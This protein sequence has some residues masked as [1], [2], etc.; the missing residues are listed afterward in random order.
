MDAVP[1]RT[2]RPCTLTGR[3][4]PGRAPE[5]APATS[6]LPLPP[7]PLP[8]SKH[9]FQRFIAHNKQFEKKD[10]EWGMGG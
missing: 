1:R 8:K 9:I 2:K 6:A 4:V 3:E 10:Q 7:P 5:N